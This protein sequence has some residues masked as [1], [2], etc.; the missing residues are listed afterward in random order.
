MFKY[1]LFHVVCRCIRAEK[2]APNLPT[3][4]VLLLWAMPNDNQTSRSLFHEMGMTDQ[5]LDGA[6]SNHGTREKAESAVLYYH[7]TRTD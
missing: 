5:T 3:S 4:H 6:T 7:Q 2:I 1:V